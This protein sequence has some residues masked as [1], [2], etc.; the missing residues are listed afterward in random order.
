MRKILHKI[1]RSGK[2]LGQILLAG[3]GFLVGL[4]ILLWSIQVY[5][6]I[7][8]LL[9]GNRKS[10]EYLILSKPIS[11]TNTILFSNAHFSEVEV[12]DLQSQKFV[13]E[14]GAFTANQFSV[15]AYAQQAGFFSEMFFESIDHRYIDN[16]PANFVWDEKSPVLPII[17][18][19]DMLDLYNFGFALS[20]G[21]NLPPISKSTA[22]L[23]TISIRLSGD[24][25]QYTLNARIVG[26]SERIPS[27]LVPSN[28]ME[29]ANQRIGKGQKTTPSRLLVKLKNA[30]D[31]N[32]AQ[33]LQD[34][35]YQ[36][37]QERLQ[38]S[39]YAGLIQEIMAVVALL[40]GF[41]I[42]LSFVVFLLNFRVVIA[43][44]K[45]EI[46]LLIQ[47]GYTQTMLASYL[48]RYFFVGIVGLLCLA[49][50]LLYYADLATY[51]FL[52]ARGLEVS[53]GITPLVWFTGIGFGALTLIA[54]IISISR[55]LRAY[56][57]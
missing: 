24:R 45:S 30:A 15:V 50:V 28:F 11:M 23:V 49:F 3:S 38:N 52:T 19:Q 35:G 9:T 56:Q 5:G 47:L 7:S 14:V 4:L 37:N 21:G 18:S 31:P 20:K 13:D 46:S 17:I 57:S 25:G 27:V 42:A 29:W 40:G 2:N 1:F 22:K 43:E 36:V 53:S 33:Y 26:F 16:V 55:L 51:Q 8:S 32:L 48:M 10:S 6:M 41:F 44:A 39:R 54:N 34:K 12:K